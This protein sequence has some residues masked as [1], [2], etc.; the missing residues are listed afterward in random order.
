MDTLITWAKENYN[1]ISLLIGLIGIIIGFISL[2]HELN[3]RKRKKRELK[4][5]IAT[6]EKQLH[7]MEMSTKAGFNALE[8]GGLEM[9]KSA[10][11]AEI[12]QL[13]KQL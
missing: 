5:Q 7:S 10:L 1:L 8:Y 2:S 4:N 13:K 9:Q 11:Q 3:E 6:K 12:E